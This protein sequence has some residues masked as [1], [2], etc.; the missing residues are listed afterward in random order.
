MCSVS[1]I[2]LTFQGKENYNLKEDKYVHKCFSTKK[3]RSNENNAN[4]GN[5][6]DCNCNVYF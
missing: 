4:I 3:Y 1:I 5:F 2:N 6:L